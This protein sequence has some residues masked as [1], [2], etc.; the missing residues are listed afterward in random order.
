MI[1][2]TLEA[3][4]HLLAVDLG[5]RF[6][7]S[8]YTLEGQL[9]NYSS[10]HC[11]NYASL[12]RFAYL[13]LKRLPHSSYLYI[14][15]GGALLK[16]WQKPALK[17]FHDCIQVHARQWRVDVLKVSNIDSLSG[18][19]AK[20]KAIEQASKVIKY[21]SGKGHHT[22]RHDSAEAILLGWW[23]LWTL[24]YVSDQKFQLIK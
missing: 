21:A 24:G 12:K 23:G 15:G 6:A 16:A 19:E 13:M 22:L 3:V 8:L 1:P 2:D 10:H 17:S 14:E 20:N 5:L 7:W 11:P 4:P 18:H 9:L